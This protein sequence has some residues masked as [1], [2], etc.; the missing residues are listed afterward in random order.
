MLTDLAMVDV[1]SNTSALLPVRWDITAADQRGIWRKERL[2]GKIEM[3]MKRGREL[4]DDKEEEAELPKDG[5]T[6]FK[7]ERIMKK[8]IQERL[9]FGDTDT[10]IWAGWMSRGFRPGGVPESCRV[11]ESFT[12]YISVTLFL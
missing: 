1:Q 10:T 6:G 3:M 8:W 4:L 12:I 11:T 5:D 9:W 7:T 2:N